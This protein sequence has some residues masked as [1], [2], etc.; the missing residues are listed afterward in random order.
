MRSLDIEVVRNIASDVATVLDQRLNDQRRSEPFRK[1]Y[2]RTDADLSRDL[3]A[4]LETL[5]ASLSAQHPAVAEE[6]DHDYL[7]RLKHLTQE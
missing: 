5:V 4:R 7:R 6:I 3:Q 1:L 2:E